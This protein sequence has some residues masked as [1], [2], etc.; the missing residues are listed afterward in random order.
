MNAITYTYLGEAVQL[1]PNKDADLIQIGDR[2]VRVVKKAKKTAVIIK[3]P[4]V[5]NGYQHKV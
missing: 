2:F 3:F 5:S 4:E 1:I